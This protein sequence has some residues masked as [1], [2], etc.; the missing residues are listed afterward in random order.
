MEKSDQARGTH[1]LE[2]TEKGT[3]QDTE[4]SDQTRGTHQLEIIEE[5]TSQDKERK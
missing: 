5:G 1:I 4:E 2:T 3:I